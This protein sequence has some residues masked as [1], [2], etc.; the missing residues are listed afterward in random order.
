VKAQ[1]TSAKAQLAGLAADLRVAEAQLAASAAQITQREAMARQIEVDLRNSEIR[2][3]VSGV[4][5]Q[6]QVELGQTVA[7][8][9]QSPTL[10]LVADDLRQME[11]SANIDEADVGRI[12]PDQRA[13]FTVSAFPGRTFEGTVKQVRLGS[14]TVQNVVIYTAIV[15]IENP[16]LELLPGM[17]AT[18]QIETD[19]RDGVVRV[20]SAALRWRPPMTS[21][22]SGPQSPQEQEA[23]WPPEPNDA[24]ERNRAA[25]LGRVFT[26]GPDG[27][28]QGITVRI[29]ATEDSATEIVSGLEPGRE[30]IVGGGPPAAQATASM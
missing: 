1:L 25:Q 22:L 15:S 8:A 11:I 2:A 21:E 13:L 10:F 20:P 7:A 5:V 18:L 3:P 28:P 27:K 17:T 29:G 30:V 24:R 19:R 6:R 12:K 16:D 9:L 4:V 23:G 14:Q 26:V